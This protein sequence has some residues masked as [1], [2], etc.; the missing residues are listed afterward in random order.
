MV[1]DNDGKLGLWMTLCLSIGGMIGAGIFM[2]PVALAPF[3]ANAVAGW[4]VSS[5]GALCIAFALSRLTRSGSAEGI[6]A[7]IERAFGP[8]IGYLVAWSCWCSVWAANAAIAIAAASATSSV[9]PVL[10]HPVSVA[11]TAMAF[12]AFLTVVNALGARSAGGMAILTVAIKVLPLFAVVVIMFMHGIAGQSFQPFAPAPLSL[13]NIASTAALTFFAISGFETA[14]FPVDKVR[15]PQRTLPIAVLVGTA[16]VAAIYLFSSTAVLLLLPANV[17]LRRPRRLR[18]PLLRSGVRARLRSPLS[19]WRLALSA[20][21][22]VEFLSLA[23]WR[24]PWRYGRTCR[25]SWLPLAGEPL[26]WRLK[27]FH[28]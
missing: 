6:Q 27:F 3:G 4:L 15:N 25:A 16:I 20:A 17:S 14:L 10:A 22:M 7:Y 13:G 2:L 28:L 1:H 24:I 8:T 21:S 11:L 12:I 26:P 5:A 9:F 18:I 19:E 23:N